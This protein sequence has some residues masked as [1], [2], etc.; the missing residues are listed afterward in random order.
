MCGIVEAREES[1]AVVEVSV[2][3]LSILSSRFRLYSLKLFDAERLNHLNMPDL[4]AQPGR[5]HPQLVEGWRMKTL[6]LLELQ[7]AEA[8][9]EYSK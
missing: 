7:T 5:L 6:R 9:A 8:V 2:S 1:S 4:T 3:P